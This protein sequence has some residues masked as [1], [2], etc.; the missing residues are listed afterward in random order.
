MLAFLL[1]QAALPAIAHDTSEFLDAASCRA[2][3]AEIARQARGGGYD[4]VEGP[5]DIAPGDVRIHTVAAEGSGHRITEHRCEGA[6]LSG[7]SWTRSMEPE[8]TPFT[9]ESIAPTLPWVKQPTRQQ[10]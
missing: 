8:E 9:I 1:A 2:R 7:R 6:R 5:Y 4:A 10:Q 3:L